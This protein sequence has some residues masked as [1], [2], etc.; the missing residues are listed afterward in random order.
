MNFSLFPPF[1]LFRFRQ[2][3]GFRFLKSYP[4][5]LYLL[6]SYRVPVEIRKIGCSGELGGSI[7]KHQGRTSI[8]RTNVHLNNKDHYITLSRMI[9]LTLYHLNL[10][11]INIDTILIVIQL[12][13]QKPLRC[14]GRGAGLDWTRFNLSVV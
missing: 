4:S 9:E 7:S 6:S 14:E 2:P 13:V 5:L 1:F 11:S 12:A 10:N 3:L 8:V